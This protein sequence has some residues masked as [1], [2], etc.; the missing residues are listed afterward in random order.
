MNIKHFHKK[1]PF[2]NGK[3]RADICLK[4][5]VF[6]AECKR[7]PGIS[8]KHDVSAEYFQ[9]SLAEVN[10]VTSLRNTVHTAVRVMKRGTARTCTTGERQFELLLEVPIIA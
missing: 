6:Q 2:E 3:T 4:V 10:D 9:Q 1:R 7:I 8:F 5:N